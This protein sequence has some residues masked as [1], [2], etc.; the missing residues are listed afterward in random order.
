MKKK[1]KKINS[2]FNSSHKKEKKTRAAGNRG[3]GAK[4]K[5]KVLTDAPKKKQKKSARAIDNENTKKRN[6]STIR[7]EGGRANLNGTFSKK[8]QRN[9]EKLGGIGFLR[10]G[11]GNYNISGQNGGGGKQKR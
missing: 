3:V 5:Q 1:K 7:G 8:K 4:K 9:R 2:T 6:R 11:V 10:G